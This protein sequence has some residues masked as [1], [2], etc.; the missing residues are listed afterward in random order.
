MGF[1]K[2]KPLISDCL[3]TQEISGSEFKKRL[4]RYSVAKARSL[5]MSE[6]IKSTQHSRYN[7]IAST[8]AECGSLLWFK[9]YFE[10]D[11]LLL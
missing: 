1:D 9:N 6:Y 5:A 10:K 7:K 11:L 2:E 8:V 4:E 3:A